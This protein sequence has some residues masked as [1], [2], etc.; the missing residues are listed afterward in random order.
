M[1]LWTGFGVTF[2]VPQSRPFPV[3]DPGG[4]QALEV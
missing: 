4:S 2:R 1:N 3:L